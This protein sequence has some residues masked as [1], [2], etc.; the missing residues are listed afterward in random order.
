M[1]GKSDVFFSR[2]PLTTAL[3]LDFLSGCPDGPECEYCAKSRRA[4]E[5]ERVTPEPDAIDHMSSPEPLPYE[6]VTFKA[7]RTG[8]KVHRFSRK[9][10]GAPLKVQR[11]RARYS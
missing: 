6:G 7:R 8:G 5:A 3:V 11:A 9:P 4:V 2:S 1:L 10:N